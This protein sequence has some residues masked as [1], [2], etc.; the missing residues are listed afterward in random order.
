MITFDI[1]TTKVA[2]YPMPWV[3][4]FN[5]KYGEDTSEV[6]WICNIMLGDYLYSSGSGDSQYKALKAAVDSFPDT[7]KER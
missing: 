6:D 7:F 2:K 5:W 4:K 1:V 3:V